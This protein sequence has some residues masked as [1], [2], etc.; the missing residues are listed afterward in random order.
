[1]MQR[2]LY[3]S[4][5]LGLIVAALGCATSF[6]SEYYLFSGQIQDAA[7]GQSIPRASVYMA[8]DARDFFAPPRLYKDEVPSYNK[9]ISQIMFGRQGMNRYLFFKADEAGRFTVVW[10]RDRIATRPFP[11]IFFLPL[12]RSTIAVMAAAPGY[13]DGLVT[14][15]RSIQ[16]RHFLA[17]RHS[18][19]LQDNA[20][21]PIALQKG[22]TRGPRPQPIWIEYLRTRYPVFPL[23]GAG[24]E[25]AQAESAFHRN[26]FSKAL[27]H[28]DAAL[29]KS[30][31]HPYVQLMRLDALF[32]LGRWAEVIEQGE[33]YLKTYPEVGF[34]HKIVADAALRL[35][36]RDLNH[37]H[38]VRAM[39]LDPEFRASFIDL[40]FTDLAYISAPEGWLPVNQVWQ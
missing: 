36:C 40:C 7:T 12:R 38:L 30:P 26:D 31:G 3:G 13:S 24:A 2:G 37:A 23:G 25:F 6:R 39:Q 4:L 28:Y 21:S 10:R 33:D 32:A 17:A 20:L 27:S 5:L 8:D 19:R 34:A 14:Q 15:T 22:Q 35:G 29:K 18:V 1:M 11:L 16:H 9:D